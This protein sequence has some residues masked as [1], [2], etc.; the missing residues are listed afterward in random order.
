MAKGREK[1]V[2]ASMVKTYE[3]YEEMLVIFFLV[4]RGFDANVTDV[5]LS[6]TM[7][8]IGIARTYKELHEI[9]R[10]DYRLLGIDRDYTELPELTWNIFLRHL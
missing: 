9:A 10:N 6:F 7:A 1:C 2:M 5:A 8:W 3:L 4:L